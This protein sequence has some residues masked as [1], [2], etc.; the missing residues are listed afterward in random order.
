MRKIVT[1]IIVLSL[2]LSAC[3]E[4]ISSRATDSQTVSLTVQPLVGET[5]TPCSTATEV[6]SLGGDMQQS[7]TA[8][9]VTVQ[10]GQTGTGTGLDRT[11]SPE[12][13]ATSEAAFARANRTGDTP[14]MTE[15]PI[16][17]GSQP[18]GPE[19]PAPSGN[20]PPETSPTP[21]AAPCP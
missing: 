18:L 6:T 4:R 11:P 8:V 5:R 15:T 1:A 9:T 10:S 17:A 13:L 3:G 21:S 14:V 20:I 2:A 7:A 12:E 16:P 19:Q